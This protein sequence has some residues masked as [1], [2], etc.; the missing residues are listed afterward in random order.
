MPSTQKA[1]PP[2]YPED[3]IKTAVAAPFGLTPGTHLLVVAVGVGWWELVVH[4]A[5]FVLWVPVS[6][7]TVTHITLT[8]L[9]FV[10]YLPTQVPGRS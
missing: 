1:G 5:A 6:A 2:S 8:S 9:V 3:I 4:G 7:S 10:V